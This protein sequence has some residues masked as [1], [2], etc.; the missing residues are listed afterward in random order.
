MKGVAE[1]CDGSVLFNWSPVAIFESDVL[2]II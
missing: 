2:I 1:Y